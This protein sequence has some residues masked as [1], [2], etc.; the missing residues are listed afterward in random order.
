MKVGFARH[1]LVE[2][3]SRYVMLAK[4]NRRDTETVVTALIK[5]SHNLP[6]EL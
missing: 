6:Q 2:R 4:A 1:A 3:Q 5:H